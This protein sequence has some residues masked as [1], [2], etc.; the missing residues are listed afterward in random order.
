MKQLLALIFA[1]AAFGHAF[2][3]NPERGVFKTVDGGKTWNKVF[4]LDDKTG[5][6]DMAV[7]KNNI[8][9]YKI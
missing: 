2:G 1:V 7:E 3:P 9:I 6:I 4:Y 5:I 8:A